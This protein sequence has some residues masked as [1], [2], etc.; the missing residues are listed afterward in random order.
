[1]EYLVHFSNNLV[2]NI[3]IYPIAVRVILEPSDRS[4]VQGYV[5][6]T[7]QTQYK[8]LFIHANIEKHGILSTFFKLF[9]NKHLYLLYFR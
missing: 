9:S 4:F 1:M 2:V 6:T 3:F 7:I 8:P 5:T